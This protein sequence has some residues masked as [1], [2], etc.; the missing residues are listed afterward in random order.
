MTVSRSTDVERSLESWPTQRADLIVLTVGSS[1][2]LSLVRR[3]RATTEV[4]L[5]VVAEGLEEAVH[6]VLLDTGA[7]LVVQRPFSARLLVAQVRALLRRTADLPFFTLS[8]LSGG[9][10]T[11][12][13]GTRTVQIENQGP[14][15]LTQLE[16]R[17]LHTL[18]VH[19]GQVLPSEVLVEQV[20]GYAGE[21]DRDLVRGLVSRLRAKIE[22]D[23]RNPRYVVT[24]PGVGYT[25]EERS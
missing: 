7:D 11:L 13:P 20:W 16:F 23:P 9:D 1:S 4:P 15:R 3:W 5:V 19:R 18:L 17:L 12:D 10:L 2:P 6:V 8:T 22:P 24:V 14:K 21:G 25:F